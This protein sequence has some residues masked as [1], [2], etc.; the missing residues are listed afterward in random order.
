MGG[1]VG[2]MKPLVGK[3]R[4]IYL[5]MNRGI[6]SNNIAPHCAVRRPEPGVNSTIESSILGVCMLYDH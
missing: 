4:V 6:Y 1:G 2:G 3:S 5:V